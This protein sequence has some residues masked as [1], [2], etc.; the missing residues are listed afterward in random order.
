MSFFL[1]F[2]C[3]IDIKQPHIWAPEP[4]GFVEVL[5]SYTEGVVVEQQVGRVGA[6]EAEG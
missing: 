3:T 2:F 6:L 4:E 1:L 5:N